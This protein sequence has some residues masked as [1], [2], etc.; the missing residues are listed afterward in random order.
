MEKSAFDCDLTYIKMRKILCALFLVFLAII[1]LPFSS[2]ADE[3]KSSETKDTDE[4][5]SDFKSIIPEDVAELLPEGFENTDIKDISSLFNEKYIS[6]LLSG[7]FE[8]HIKEAAKILAQMLAIVLIIALVE[9]AG[10]CLKSGSSRIVFG[11]IATLCC[12]IRLYVILYA[13][14]ELTKECAENIN[15]FMSS[16]GSILS[17]IYLI[18]GNILTAQSHMCWLAVLLTTVE[19]ATVYLI[20]PIFE[21]SMA[22]TLVS[23]FDKG[24]TIKPFVSFLQN[25]TTWLIVFIMT[26]ISVIMSFQT[27]IS[28]ASD[29]V[30][31]RTVKFAA[32]Q[33]IPV[34]GGMVSESVKTLSSGLLLIRSATG[35]GAIIIILLTSLSPLLSMLLSKY[36]LSVSGALSKMFGEVPVNDLINDSVRLINQMAAMIVI[37]DITYI[38]CLTVFV[39]TTAAVSI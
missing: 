11:R 34:I 14:F 38:Y 2:Y 39:K 22:I 18:G 25:F 4:I 33:S 1:F 6:G 23:S 24:L 31:M 26:V 9:C 32:S 36:A 16:F 10:D 29:S 12:A 20:F 27:S 30:S 21:I 37:L 35:G 5:L 8:R 19:K 28:A 13:V 17:A 15:A 7:L 3:P